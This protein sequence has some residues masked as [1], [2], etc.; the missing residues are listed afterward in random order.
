MHPKP[1]LRSLFAAAALL[2]L[3]G[4]A[5]VPAAAQPTYGPAGAQPARG[6][7]G[8]VELTPYVAYRFGGEIDTDDRFF[9]DDDDDTDIEEGEA[10]GLILD[11]PLRDGFMLELLV[12]HQETEAEIDEGLFEPSVGLGDVS[13]T[14]GHVGILYGWRLGQVEPFVVGSLGGTL[15]DPDLPGSDEETRFSLGFGGGVKLFFAEH[16][17]LRV[18]ARGFWTD[19]GDDDDFDDRFDRDDGSGLFQGE[20]TAGLIFTW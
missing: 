12:S 11:V 16:V 15:I 7:G 3:L 19:L 4:P 6:Q 8:G 14:Y 18:E 20:A 9:R 13:V 10:F 2:A 1:L 17:G 5:A